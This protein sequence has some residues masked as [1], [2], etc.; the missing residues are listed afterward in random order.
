MI[1]VYLKIIKSDSLLTKI[2]AAIDD[3]HILTWEYDEDGDFTATQ[4]QW[5]NEA[6]MHP[7]KISDKCI[8]FGIVQRRDVPITSDVYAV[9]HGRFTEM[10][11]MHF[12]KYISNIEISSLLVEGVDV[13]ETE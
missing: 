7:F 12:D 13:F 4:P 11:L 9:Y 5:N 1:E 3:Q 6:W 2:M 10:L 8:Q